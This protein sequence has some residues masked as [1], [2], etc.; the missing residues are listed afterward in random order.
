MKSKAVH[1]DAEL[2]GKGKCF[3]QT[4]NKEGYI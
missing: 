2:E 1:G 3:K 4:K